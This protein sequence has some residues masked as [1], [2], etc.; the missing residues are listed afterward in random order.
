MALGCPGAKAGAICCG[1]TYAGK[2]GNGKGQKQDLFVM[3]LEVG[4]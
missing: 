1:W 2:L 3:Y 4:P